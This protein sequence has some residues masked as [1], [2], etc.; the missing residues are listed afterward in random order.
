MGEVKENLVQN[1][2]AQNLKRFKLPHFKAVANVVMGDPKGEVVTKTHAKL[3]VLKQ[4][5]LDADWKKRKVE[6]E[7][8]NAEKQKK[9]EVLRR[10][11]QLAEE[12]RLRREAAEKKRT[13][14][15]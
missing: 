5:K 11:K 7:K 14:L 3:L 10:Q 2:R 9:K 1:D 12:N 13:E 15:Q 4:Q 8:R 6:M